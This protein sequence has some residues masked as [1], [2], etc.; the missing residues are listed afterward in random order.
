MD[1]VVA[2]GVPLAFAN[3]KQGYTIADRIGVRTLRDPYTHKPFVHFYATKRVS[4]MVTDAKAFV[5]LKVQA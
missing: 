2:G 5:V 4:G 1:G 3:M